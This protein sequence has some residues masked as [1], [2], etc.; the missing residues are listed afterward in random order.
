MK[1]VILLM[2]ITLLYNVAVSQCYEP[3]IKKADAAYARGDWQ[4]AYEFYK[5]ASKCPD[6]KNFEND[7]KA[8]DGIKKCYPVLK[9]DGQKELEITVGRESGE[10][11]FKVTSSKLDSEGWK[12]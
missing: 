2:L 8:K 1:K 10:R 3:N 11:T 6:A 7:K 9:V 12:M 4:T 5:Q